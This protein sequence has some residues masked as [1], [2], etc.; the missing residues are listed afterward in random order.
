MS[1]IEI[2]TQDEWINRVKTL[3]SEL[4]NILEDLRCLDST[5]LYYDRNWDDI[6]ESSVGN[7]YDEKYIKL[8]DIN[9]ILDEHSK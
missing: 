8:E 4:N 1:S 7:E 9:R 3:E 6:R 2:G 5:Y